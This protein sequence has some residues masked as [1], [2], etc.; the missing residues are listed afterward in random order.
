MIHEGIYAALTAE[1]ALLQ[2][3][4]HEWFNDNVRMFLKQPHVGSLRIL[5]SQTPI[6][7]TTRTSI[8]AFFCGYNDPLKAIDSAFCFHDSTVQ[9]NAQAFYDVL[10]SDECF[11]KNMLPRIGTYI[12]T[13]QGARVICQHH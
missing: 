5:V 4:F 7:G 11:V 8:D 12:Y 3:R 1:H 6:N 10:M 13:L 2:A 9:E